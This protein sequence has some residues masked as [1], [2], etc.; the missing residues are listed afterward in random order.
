MY[1]VCLKIKRKKIFCSWKLSTQINF[2]IAVYQVRS[3][4][5]LLM[6]IS[7]QQPWLIMGANNQRNHQ[8]GRN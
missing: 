7:S 6:V 4:Y 3:S 1:V 5:G 2:F 8:Y